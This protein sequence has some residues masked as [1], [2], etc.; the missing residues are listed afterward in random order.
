MKAPAFTESQATGSLSWS[1]ISLLPQG[2]L[3]RGRKLGGTGGSTSVSHTATQ[4]LHTTLGSE[5]KLMVMQPLVAVT[6]K[7]PSAP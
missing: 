4:P 7:G 1:T 6:L 3:A 5:M 2:T